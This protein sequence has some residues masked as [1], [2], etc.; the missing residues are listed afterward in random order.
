MVAEIDRHA[1]FHLPRNGKV[2]PELEF[3]PKTAVCPVCLRP[4]Q[5]MYILTKYYSS[6]NQTKCIVLF[7]RTSYTL[8]T[9]RAYSSQSE[10]R[11]GYYMRI[12]AILN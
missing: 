1:V 12:V 6:L 8:R 5:N 4:E 9:L 3:F 11:I 2:L 10:L 7:I